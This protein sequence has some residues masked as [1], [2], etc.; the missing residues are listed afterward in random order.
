MQS[1][2]EARSNTIRCY[3]NN[4]TPDSLFR[5]VGFCDASKTAY[6][7]VVYICVEIDSSHVT[8]FVSCKTR[9]APLKQQTIPLLELLSVLLLSK[10][11]VCTTR[12]LEPEL[13]IDQLHY[14]TDSNIALY[15]I[16]RQEREWKPFIQN[17]VNE[18]RKLTSVDE[19]YHCAGTENPA[20]IPSRGA[21]LFAVHS[22]YVA[23]TG[24]KVARTHL[25]K[26]CLRCQ[27]HVRMNRRSP[28]RLTA[29]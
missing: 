23:R 16:R 24:C 6:A 26:T 3:F 28:K 25:S 13:K 4:T 1:L 27:K 14:F 21:S 7:A 18:I 22:G 11:M 9:V 17:Q 20:D 15:W 8:R 2:Q 12:A 29:F 19:W 10:L 5:L